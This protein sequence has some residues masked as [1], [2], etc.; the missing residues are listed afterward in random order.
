MELPNN[1]WL[2]NDQDQ[3]YRN[4]HTYTPTHTYIHKGYAQWNSIKL[5]DDIREDDK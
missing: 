3:K 4:T 1:G 2:T 5:F